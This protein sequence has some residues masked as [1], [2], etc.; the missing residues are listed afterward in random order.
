ML[1]ISTTDAREDLSSVVNQV[2]FG[3]TRAILQR[4]GKD[5]VAVI[6]VEDLRLLERLEE[7]LQESLD[8]E[9]ARKALSNPENDER[10]PWKEVKARIGL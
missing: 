4:H 10:I 9:E 6:P 8:L 7:E 3:K 5:L 1:L 2:A